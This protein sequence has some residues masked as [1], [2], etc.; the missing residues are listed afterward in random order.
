MTIFEP[1]VFET[2]S[3]ESVGLPYKLARFNEMPTVKQLLERIEPFSINDTC[4]DVLD[5]FIQDDE[6]LTSAIIDDHRV[7]VGIMNR[8]RMTEIFIKPYARDLHHKKKISEIMD[9]KPIIVDIQTSIDDVAQMIIDSGMHHMA[10]GFIIVKNEVYAGIATGHALLEEITHR[11][12]RD[13]YYLAHY[14]QLTGLANRLLFMD[15][16]QQACQNTK[17]NDKMV[18]LIF[19]DLDRFK[20]INDTLGHSFADQLLVTVAK[21]LSA[22]VRESDTVARLGGDEFVVILQN[23]QNAE[24]TERVA[25]ALVDAIRQPLLISNREIQLTVSIG[26]ALYPQHDGTPDGLIRKADAAMYQVKKQGRND[27]LIYSEDLD[28]GMAEQISLEAHLRKS[29]ENRELSL[30]YQPQIHLLHNRVVGVEALLR[31]QHPELGLISPAKFIPIAEETG[32]IHSIGEWVLREACR[33][34]CEWLSQGLPRLR[35]AINISAIQFRQK[36]FCAII[37][38]VAQETGIDPQYIELELTESMVMVYSEHTVETLAELRAFGIK[39]AIDD[40]G[41][42]YSS[43]DYLRKFPVDRIK[44]DQSFIRNIKTIPANDA[45]VSAIIAMGD[46]LGLEMIAEGVETP[47]ELECIK[48]HHCQEV[49][50]Y[51]FSRP[52]P[53]YEFGPWFRQFQQC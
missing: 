3:Q 49:Q 51:H 23:I 7:P 29:L 37:K 50:G 28:Q 46:N 30:F 21:R 39:L 15:R 32:L 34:H 38:Q 18:A 43:L 24:D 42:G 16:L 8:G 26:I 4:V 12:Q 41:T 2:I 6:L 40:F 22:C 45:I 36:N 25:S 27:F 31:W 19:V 10:H 53:A 44:I 11:K 33:Q 5:R 52:V 1:K 14:D 48:N 20:Y 9:P 47:D 35:I 17:R 13:L